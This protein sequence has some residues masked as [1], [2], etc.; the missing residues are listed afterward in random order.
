MRTF[1]ALELPEEFED[2]VADLARQLSGML[3]GRFMRRETYHVTLAFL[4]EIGEADSRETIAAL[5]G[6][7]RSC[8]SVVLRPTGLGTFGKP[9]D[10]TLWLGLEQADELMALADELRACLDERGISYDRKPFRPH[11][12]LARRA[13][14]PKAPLDGL[15][16]PALATA[17]R[18]TLFK[19]ILTQ[20]GATY[21]PL[22]SAELG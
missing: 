11:I 22:Y 5:D 10:C 21:K 6:V 4:G 7:T 20:E 14:L 15:V 2:E 13:V 1:V 19:S 16:F 9:H 17:S 18:L 3:K 12:T 8:G